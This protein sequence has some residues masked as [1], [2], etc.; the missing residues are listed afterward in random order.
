[1]CGF[2]CR[3]QGCCAYGC[4]DMLG[5]TVLEMN[6]GGPVGF[7]MGCGDADMLGF[8]VLGMN[9]GRPVGFGMGC[10]DADERTI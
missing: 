2:D 8:A 6:P 10:G 1:M 4:G 3:G 5:F 7:G 9:P